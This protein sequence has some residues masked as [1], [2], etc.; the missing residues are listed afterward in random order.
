MKGKGQRAKMHS[1]ERKCRIQD[2]GSGNQ[3]HEGKIKEE[4]Q[5]ARYKE[6][7]GKRI[8]RLKAKGKRRKSHSVESRR[9]K[10]G[11]EFNIEENG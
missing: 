2:T 7:G 10:A 5:G 4:A 1:A 6:Q 8:A 3:Y 9:Q 11:P